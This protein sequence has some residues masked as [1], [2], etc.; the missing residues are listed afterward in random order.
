MFREHTSQGLGVFVFEYRRLTPCLY[1]VAVFVP[2]RFGVCRN[3][4]V[5]GKTLPRDAVP[6]FVCVQHRKVCHFAIWP[7]LRNFFIYRRSL[8]WACYCNSLWLCA[9]SCKSDKRRVNLSWVKHVSQC[10][11]VDCRG[12]HE[13]IVAIIGWIV[14][15]NGRSVGKDRSAH[16]RSRSLSSLLLRVRWLRVVVRYY[17]RGHHKRDV[18]L[19]LWVTPP[20]SLPDEAYI[21]D[22]TVVIRLCDIGILKRNAFWYRLFCDIIFVEVVYEFWNP[23]DLSDNR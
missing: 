4:N 11:C 15:T 8:L 6:G 19:T 22:R 5:W 2:A 23:R 12:L 7:W 3:C 20:V 9:V 16:E 18:G 13:A 1:V 21:A 10:S 14:Y 17:R